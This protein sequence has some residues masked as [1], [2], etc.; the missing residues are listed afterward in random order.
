[1]GRSLIVE[2]RNLRAKNGRLERENESL[3]AECSQACHDALI[4]QMRQRFDIPKWLLTER[5]YEILANK[6]LKGIEEFMQ[7][8]ARMLTGNKPKLV[9][10][11][12]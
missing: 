5:S 6:D 7:Q 3:R 9:S 11:E 4:E 1:M 12:V 8:R 2:I 10:K